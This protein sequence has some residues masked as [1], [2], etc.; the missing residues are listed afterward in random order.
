MHIT[1]L[2]FDVLYEINSFN[3][4]NNLL[5]SSNE[6]KEHKYKLF[7][8]KLNESY[9]YKYCEDNSFLIDKI[10]SEKQISLNLSLC[11]KYIKNIS[12]LKI[13]P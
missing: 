10:R 2:P 6:F 4:I 5:N 12:K 7:N 9:S 3:N 11:N 13:I 8:W 1:E